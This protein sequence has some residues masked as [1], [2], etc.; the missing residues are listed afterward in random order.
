MTTPNLTRRAV[1]IGLAALA[2]LGAGPAVAQASPL[3]Q[4]L[5]DPDCGCCGDWIA[6]MGNEGF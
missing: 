2:P 3:M 1:V 5:K 4:V 6:I